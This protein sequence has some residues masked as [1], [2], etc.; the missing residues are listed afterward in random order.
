MT[1]RKLPEPHQQNGVTLIE[2]MIALTLGMIIVIAVT[3]IYLSNRAAFR[4]HEALAQIQQNAR[5]AFELVNND[6]REAGGNPCGVPSSQVVNALNSPTTNWWSNW[7]GGI[8]QGFDRDMGDTAPIAIGTGATQRA[9]AT[10]AIIVRGTTPVSTGQELVITN[11]NTGATTFTISSAPSNISVGDV[12][13]ACDPK[14]AAIFQV[15]SKDDGAKTVVH[16]IGAAVVSPGNCSKD[17]GFPIDPLSLGD[18]TKVTTYQFEKTG[19]GMLSRLYSVFW[20]IGNNDHGGTSL[21]RVRTAYTTTPAKSV[22]NDIQEI[23]DGVTDMKLEYLGRTGSVLDSAF[24]AATATTNWSLPVAVRIKLTVKSTN[25][26]GTDQKP[27]ER[28]FLSV[29]SLRNREIVQ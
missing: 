24:L 16:D 9:S 4:S 6:V 5:I 10:D 19:S 26:A 23:A 14:E 8:V 28:E 11:H 21:F 13:M 27:L 7:A 29:V 1:S 22:K 18:C 20:Y 17:L 12:L 15:T 2:L 25:K 3:N